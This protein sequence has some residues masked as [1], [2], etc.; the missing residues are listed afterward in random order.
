MQEL[1]KITFQFFVRYDEG[2]NDHSLVGIGESIIGLEHL[3]P[4][5]VNAS[6]IDD[7]EVFVKV[8]DVKGGCIIFGLS[9]DVIVAINI[10]KDLKDFYDIL[11]FLTPDIS[12]MGAEIIKL[13]NDINNFAST[14]PVDY[15]LVKL[16]LDRGSLGILLSWFLKNLIKILPAQKNTPTTEFGNYVIPTKIAQ[17]AHK[18]INTNIFKKTFHPF[19][20]GKIKSIE[21]GIDES[22]GNREIITNGNF[23]EYLGE[24]Q[25]ILSD[26]LNGDMKI[27]Q[28]KFVSWQRKKGNS[29]S[30]RVNG[31]Q[32]SYRDLVCYPC[33]SMQITDFTDYLNEDNISLKVEISRASL[34]E[35]PR[36]IIHEINNVI[37]SFDI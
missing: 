33:E 21:F 15:D 35:K 10:F 24:D 19:V 2:L 14:N 11:Q 36:L 29:L 6:G 16:F 23:G 25:K 7:E 28:G 5:L 17:K 22:F 13:H 20:D 31:L 1:N 8:I 9:V 30:F 4:K 3:L 26:W 27:I 37:L 18:L 12:A 32:R 34:Y